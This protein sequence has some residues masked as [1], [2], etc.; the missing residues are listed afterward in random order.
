M[1]TIAADTLALDPT[2]AALGSAT[3]ELPRALIASAAGADACPE[4]TP[5]RIDKSTVPTSGTRPYVR[6]A[7]YP[8]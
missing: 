6:M 2:A 8:G 1:W 3:V 7:K 5:A 4:P